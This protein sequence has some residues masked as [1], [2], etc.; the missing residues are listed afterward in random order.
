MLTE[1]VH[2]NIVPLLGSALDGPQPCLVYALMVGG[3]LDDRLARSGGRRTLTASERILIV[4]DVARGLAHLHTHAKVVHR[5]VK[6]ANVLLDRG[7]VG[8]IGDFGLARTVSDGA[9][10]S[11]QLPARSALSAHH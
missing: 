4:S 10:H 11:A 2:P 1:V 6:S 7:L 5:D 3:A 8:R 9:T